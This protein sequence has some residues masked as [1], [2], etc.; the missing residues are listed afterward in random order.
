MMFA[1][2]NSGLLTIKVRKQ[3]LN[4]ATEIDH[5]FTDDLGDETD[6]PRNFATA[7]RGRLTN[8]NGRLLLL[9]AWVSDESQRMTDMFPEVMS[10]DDTEETNSEERPL[11]TLLGF[12]NENKVFPVM[13]AFMPSKA[14]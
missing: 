2:F 1:H 4:N 13:S 9:C 8:G 5:E 10:G 11:Y 14:Q 6:N 7:M 12:D 3:N